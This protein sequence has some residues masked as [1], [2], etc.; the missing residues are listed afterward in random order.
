MTFGVSNLPG[1]ANG[2][3]AGA[4]LSGNGAMAAQNFL[5]ALLGQE[6]APR[7]GG[8]AF[9]S[10]VKDAKNPQQKL[11]LIDGFAAGFAAASEGAEGGKGAEGAA[12]GAAEGGKGAGGAGGGEAAQGAKGA[13]GAVG[14]NGAQGAGEGDEAASPQDLMTGFQEI[15]QR[16]ADSDLPK[17]AKNKLLDGIAELM[18]KLK[19]EAGGAGGNG[20][21]QG[22]GGPAAGADGGKGAGAAEGAGGGQ[23]AEEASPAGAGKAQKGACEEKPRAACGEGKP[24][25]AEGA[26]GS[27][28]AGGCSKGSGEQNSG[29]W[30]HEVKDG[31]ATIR[32]GDK[33]TI[34]ARED[35]ASWTVTNNETGKSTKISGDPHVDVNNDG[36]NDFDFK[37]DMT[38]KLDDGTKIT[39]G[40][41]PGEN[42]TTY[43]SKLTITNGD[44]AMQ[45]SGL[46][47]GD[48]D[49]KL[50][51]TQSTEG[52]TVDDLQNDGAQTIYEN[53][54]AWENKNGQSVT[55]QVIDAAEAAAA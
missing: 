3:L 47:S 50:A 43:S 22:A 48:G 27:G 49:G 16:I 41:V 21:A 42:G 35:G 8:Q 17:G 37:K 38:F 54:G 40:T 34:Q 19:G 30:T 52:E 39:V 1:G 11:A 7:S 36:K 20:A 26:N 5:N 12:K 55:Q 13:N 29:A 45:V 44:N 9:L 14:A 46:N 6:D 2:G 10:D 31:E 15:A 23:G 24:E 25:A 32:L 53:G 4:G 51:V 18:S 28:E 33:Y